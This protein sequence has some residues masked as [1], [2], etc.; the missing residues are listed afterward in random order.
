MFK[1]DHYKN[2]RISSGFGIDRGSYKHSGIDYPG[3][4]KEDVYN[5]IDGIVENIIYDEKYFGTQC[6]MYS[7]PK[8][9][10]DVNDK[11]YHSYCHLSEVDV[12]EGQFLESGKII[13]KMGN[14]GDSFTVYDSK[15]KLTDFYRPITDKEKENKKCNFGVHL[16]LWFFQICKKGKTTPL[17]RKL[18]SLKIISKDTIGDTHFYQWGKLIF[19]P[20]VIYKY[21]KPW[22]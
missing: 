1:K 2:K 6:I 4:K 13:G 7:N 17:F 20:R 9:A 10:G 21:F 22:K 14:S 16:H 8:F 3:T 15:G 19:A 5:Q 12:K 11:L 18:K